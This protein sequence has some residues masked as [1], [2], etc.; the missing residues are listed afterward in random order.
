MPELSAIVCTHDRPRDLERCLTALAALADPVQVIV[1]DSASSVPCRALV[2]GFRDRLT[3]LEYVFVPEPGLSLA[4]NAGVRVASGRVVAFLDDDAAPAA[5]WARRIL[6]AFARGADI[7]CVGGT[8]RA[9]FDGPR[10]RWLS[11][12]LLQLAGITRFGD[13]PREARS[14]AEWPFGANMAFRRAALEAAGTF[15]ETLGR[16]GTSLLSGE[17]SEMVERVRAAGWRVWLEPA[18]VV[19]HT[20][21]AE[22]CRGRYYWRR[23]WW[24]GISRAVNPSPQVAARLAAAVPVRLVLGVVTRDRFYLYRLAESAGYFAARLRLVA[25]P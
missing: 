22:R 20:V 3:D 14:S 10:P 21:H 2:E 11:P 16:R 15:S 1:V 19:D 25:R 17:D 9:A 7:G 5:D 8:C 13:A 23:L 18:A 24:N 6:A 4:R 12:R